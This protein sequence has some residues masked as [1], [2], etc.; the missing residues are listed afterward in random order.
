MKREWQHAVGPSKK[1][2]LDESKYNSVGKETLRL[3]SPHCR[4]LPSSSDGFKLSHTLGLPGT[5]IF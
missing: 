2:K 3:I 4:S 1:R 5:A